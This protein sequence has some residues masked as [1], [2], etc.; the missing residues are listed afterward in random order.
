MS[1][2]PESVNDLDGWDRLQHIDNDGVDL[3]SWEIDFVESLTKQLK[4]GKY[5]SDKQSEILMR[6]EE[7]R[8]Q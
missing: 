4:Q 7:Q 6:I 1:D 5:L 8:C 3:T 2:V